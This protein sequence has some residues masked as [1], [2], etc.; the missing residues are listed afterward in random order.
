M[1]SVTSINQTAFIRE[2]LVYFSSIANYMA[3]HGVNLIRGLWGVDKEDLKAKGDLDVERKGGLIRI[4][5]YK[6]YDPSIQ[7][8][9]YDSLRLE[10]ITAY[11]RNPVTEERS[12]L[13][14]WG[15][16]IESRGLEA[17]GIG[18]NVDVVV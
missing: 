4:L 15:R 11:V 6:R 3:A 9:L 10:N 16:S 2:V 8:A 17:L 13:V 12:R 14:T 5:E 1:V 7:K 18:G